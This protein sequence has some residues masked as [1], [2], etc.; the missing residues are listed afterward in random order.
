MRRYSPRVFQIASRFFRQRAL[1]E[2]IAQEVF[3]KAFIR[4]SSFEGR[5][6]FEGWLSRIATHTCLNE[7]RR[8]KRQPE[9]PVADLT[10]DDNDWLDGKLADI[11]AE[12]HQSAERS[13]V[14]ADLAERVLATL[15]PE[16][17]LVLTLIDGEGLSIKEVSDMT[18]W[19]KAK[20]KV[21]AFRAR[22]RMRKAV[23]KILKDKRS[24]ANPSLAR[25]RL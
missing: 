14:A 15:S 21:Q 9:S 12:R 13:F 19:S 3:L 7:L 22:R 25:D 16:D 18:G 20:V 4:L 17:R 11:S 2:E 8:A 5:G 1:V 24:G 10:S 6:S 23:E